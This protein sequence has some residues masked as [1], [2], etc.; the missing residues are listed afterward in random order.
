MSAR[1]EVQAPS[2]S[3]SGAAPW[4][5]AVLALLLAVGAA[6]WTLTRS[7]GQATPTHQR[8]AVSTVTHQDSNGQD[9]V[10]TGGATRPIPYQP[11]APAVAPAAPAAPAAN[12]SGGWY[13][14]MIS[15]GGAV[16]P[17]PSI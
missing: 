5:A 4:I 3:R 2:T 17:A 11:V 15:T 8:P 16:H 1:I 7:S 12:G 10:S 6:V 13:F 14:H 9:L